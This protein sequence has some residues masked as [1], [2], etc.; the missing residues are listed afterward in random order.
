MRYIL[1]DRKPV[2]AQNI[3]EN[4]AWWSDLARRVVAQTW[5]G[6][7][8]WVSTIF[9]GLDHGIGER[10]RFFETMTWCDDDY[11]GQ[12]RY[13][14]W[15]EAFLGHREVVAALA[16]RLGL[17]VPNIVEGVPAEPVPSDVP[18]PSDYERLTREDD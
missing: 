4:A 15:D 16:A 12:Q 3:L 5:V 13:E 10:V 11:E 14:T 1:V 18:P 7:K 8:Y 2:L 6:E 17:P 9:L